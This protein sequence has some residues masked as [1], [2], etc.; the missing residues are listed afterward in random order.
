M[1]T[2]TQQISIE[3]TMLTGQTDSEGHTLDHHST[4]LSEGSI[5]NQ[6]MCHPFTIWQEWYPRL[7]TSPTDALCLQSS[8]FSDPRLSLISPQESILGLWITGSGN[9]LGKEGL[10]GTN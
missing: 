10:D 9:K 5:S 7:L 8:H 4:A 1:P 2:I 6:L 3:A